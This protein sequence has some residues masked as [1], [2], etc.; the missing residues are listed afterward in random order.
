MT[1]VFFAMTEFEFVG[2]TSAEFSSK[3]KLDPW[4]SYRNHR[5]IVTKI[6]CNA[7]GHDSVCILGAGPCF[8]LNLTTLL[9]TFKQLTL[10]DIEHDVVVKGVEAQQCQDRAEIELLTGIDLLGITPLLKKYKDEQ[11][12][13]IVLNLSLIHI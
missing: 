12:D 5:D 1:G 4:V 8:D 9:N 3:Q 11:D 7:D 6:I 13:K 2:G 10:V